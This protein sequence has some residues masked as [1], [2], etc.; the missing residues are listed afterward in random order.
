[1]VRSLRPFLKYCSQI[2]SDHLWLNYHKTSYHPT[3][4][5]ITQLHDWYPTKSTRP[6]VIHTNTYYVTT[7]VTIRVHFQVRW[8]TELGPLNR[9]WPVTSEGT[10][11]TSC[12]VIYPRYRAYTCLAHVVWVC[13]RCVEGE[14]RRVP[15]SFVWFMR[16]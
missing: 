12:Y 8:K 5:Q 3:K 4:F 7:R 6:C 1:M 11:D 2:I 15:F 10:T 16:V 13:A 9:G 14:V